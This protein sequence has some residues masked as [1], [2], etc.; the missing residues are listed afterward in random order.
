MTVDAIMDE[1]EIPEEMLR[2][3][4]KQPDT[5]G[6]L[7]RSYR[8]E[9]NITQGEL[10]SRLYC[11]FATVCQVENDRPVNITQTFLLDWL[12]IVGKPGDTKAMQFWSNGR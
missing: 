8:R 1:R 4:E 12:S 3:V 10:S 11:A 6:S 9:A 5:L 2:G 7:L